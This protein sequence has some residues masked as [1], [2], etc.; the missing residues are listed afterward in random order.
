LPVLR[1]AVM[2]RGIPLRLYVDNGSAY[3]SHHVSLVCARL[4]ITL[5]HARPYQPQGKG[6]QERF[7]RTVR[8][9]LL[10]TLGET[11]LG[12]LDALNRRLWAWVEGEYHQSPHKGLDGATPMDA[13]AMRSG[14]VRGAGPELD[15]R[16]MF[17]LEAKRRVRADRTV[18][19]DGVVYEVDA[20]VVGEKVTLRFDPAR[21][22]AP[23]DVWHGGKK[24]EQARVVDT[25]AN[26]FVKRNHD[27]PEGV[28]LRDL[29][30]D[31]EPGGR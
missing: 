12:S 27:A 10:P 18:S 6:K 8:M 5:I 31:P 24:I 25:H 4:G 7:F 2:R 15:L 28:R 9:Q 14:D 23:V 17:L 13:W 19:L 1:Q 22:G 11:D 30:D 26:C 3:R 21:R 16:E 20:S 29:G